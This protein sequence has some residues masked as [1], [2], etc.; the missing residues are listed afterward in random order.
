MEVRYLADPVRF[1]RMTTAELR[2]NMLIENLF[3]PGEL[4]LVYSD[5]ERAIVGSAVP[6]GAPLSLRGSKELAAEYFTERREIGIINIGAPGIVTVGEE[7]FHLAHKEALYIGKGQHNVEFRS[8]AVQ[9]PAEFYLLSYPAHQAYPTRKVTQAQ[10]NRLDLGSAAECNQRTI[11][12]YL[13]PGVLETCQLV[14]G[15]TELAEGSVWNTMPPHTHARRTEVYFYFDMP[16]NGLVFHFC[17]EP[18]ATRHIVMR[19]KQAVLSPSW[20]IHAGAGTARYTF[21]WGMGG[22]NQEFGDMDNVAP[23]NLM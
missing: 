10:A 7:S 8:E 18:Q 19:N 21:I 22:E 2:Q 16:E 12:Q 3:K 4:T 11:F 23:V 6:T 9:T 14:M 13:R 5:S 1:Q 20:S 15:L 17:G